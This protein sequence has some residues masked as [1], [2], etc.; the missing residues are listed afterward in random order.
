MLNYQFTK[1]NKQANLL[2]LFFFFLKELGK[3]YVPINWG[4]L[5]ESFSVILPL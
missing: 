4:R 3:A 5:H 2:S 1:R